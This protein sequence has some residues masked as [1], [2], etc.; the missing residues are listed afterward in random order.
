MYPE[1]RGQSAG[2][3]DV[4]VA[5]LDGLGLSPDLKKAELVQVE[6]SSLGRAEI[7]MVVSV[8]GKLR[9]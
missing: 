5:V 9:I 6:P 3:I 7:D 2:Q 1:R 4:G 8:S